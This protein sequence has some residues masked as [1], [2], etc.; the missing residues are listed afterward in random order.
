[1]E[2]EKCEKRDWFEWS[3]LPQPLFFGPSFWLEFLQEPNHLV[4]NK[5]NNERYVCRKRS[6][7]RRSR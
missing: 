6:I 7:R 4:S 2:P 1:M 3:N 5:I